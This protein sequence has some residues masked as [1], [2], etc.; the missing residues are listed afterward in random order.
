M[1][2]VDKAEA[3]ALAIAKVAMLMQSNQD[4]QFKQMMEMFKKLVKANN[5]PGAQVPVPTPATPPRQCK[6]CP[7]C[8]RQHSKPRKCWE[9]EANKADCPAK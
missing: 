7:H 2:K 6:V 3:A 1:D 8:K 5:S 9:L 4:K